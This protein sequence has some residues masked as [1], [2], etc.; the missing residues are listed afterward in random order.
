MLQRF[1]HASWVF[2]SRDTLELR[3]ADV[4]LLFVN[5]N[6]GQFSSPVISRLQHE[7]TFFDDPFKYNL[8]FT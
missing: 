3:H 1:D 6:L 4:K 7:N 8:N 5:L 2:Y